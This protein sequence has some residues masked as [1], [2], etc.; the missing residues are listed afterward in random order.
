MIVRLLFV[1]YIKQEVS[2][3]VVSYTTKSIQDDPRLSH[4]QK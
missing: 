3:S 4:S 2:D 1:E